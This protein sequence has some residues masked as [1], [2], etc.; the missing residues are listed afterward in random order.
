MKTLFSA[1]YTLFDAGGTFKTD[2]GGRLYLYEA[3]QGATFPYCV[4]TMVSGVPEFYMPSKEWRDID[5]QF[6]IYAEDQSADNILGYSDHLAAMF[7]DA[8]LTVT[9][10][11]LVKFT[12]NLM[13]LLRDPEDG[14]WQHTTQYETWLIKN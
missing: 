2:I 13:T 9:G 11:G 12:R 6:N 14:T 7:D 8:A 5:I 4:Y 1:I 3:P 10:Y